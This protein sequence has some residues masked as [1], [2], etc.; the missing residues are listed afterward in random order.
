MPRRAHDFRG[1]TQPRRL[2]LLRAV[3]RVPGRRAGELASECGIPLN[4]VRDH[5]RVLEDEG[6]IRS[7]ALQ[8]GVRGRPPVVFHPVRE[9]ASSAAASARVV[10]AEKR[11]RMLR[12][13][14]SAEPPVLDADA[15]RQL[16]VLYEHLDDAGLDPAVDERTLSFD[17]APCRYHDMID[18]DRAL[19]CGVHARLVQDVLLHA[20]GP[21]A[22]ERLEPFVTAHHCRL[23]LTHTEGAAGS[24]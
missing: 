13:V 21:L 2:Q 16:D 3:Q 14:T 12:A 11:G 17:L 8:V 19:V 6:L 1:L 22:M 5:L 9:S 24:A 10:G 20:D 15:A 23:L 4:T 7:E 18:E